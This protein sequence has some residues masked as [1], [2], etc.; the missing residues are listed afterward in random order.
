LSPITLP[1]KACAENRYTKPALISAAI[2]I[3]LPAPKAAVKASLAVFF[4]SLL[5]KPAKFV[6]NRNIIPVF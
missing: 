5:L 1:L 6:Y 2:A 3:I 4:A